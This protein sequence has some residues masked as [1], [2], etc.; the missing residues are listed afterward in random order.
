MPLTLKIMWLRR[1]VVRSMH[2][3]WTIMVS[4]TVTTFGIRKGSFENMRNMRMLIR[5]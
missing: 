2:T 4:L 1:A 5:L 3:A